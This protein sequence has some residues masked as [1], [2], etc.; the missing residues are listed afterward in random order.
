MDSCGEEEG[1]VDRFGVGVRQQYA[2]SNNCFSVQFCFL[3]NR[4]GLGCFHSKV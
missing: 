3:F 1:E 2:G 4:E